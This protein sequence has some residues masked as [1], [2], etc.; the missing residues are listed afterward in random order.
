M[1]DWYVRSVN[2][3]WEGCWNRLWLCVCVRYLVSEFA[4]T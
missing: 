4:V 3:L 2:Q 1:K